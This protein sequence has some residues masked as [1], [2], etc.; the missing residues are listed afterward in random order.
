MALNR[1]GRGAVALLAASGLLLTGAAACED[2]G[3]GVGSN[4]EQ[5]DTDK[6]F[7]TGGSSGATEDGQGKPGEGG[8][9]DEVG[10]GG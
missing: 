4:G 2:G 3:P 1:I 5:S 8:A 7:G 9:G 10:G 6:D